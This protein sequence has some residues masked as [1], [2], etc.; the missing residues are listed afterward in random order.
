MKLG[1]LLSAATLPL[2]FAVAAQAADVAIDAAPAVAAAPAGDGL[3]GRVVNADGSPL[4]GAEII[5]R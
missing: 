4:P 2:V 5:D 1:L 3:I